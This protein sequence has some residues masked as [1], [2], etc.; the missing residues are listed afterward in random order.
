MIPCQLGC[1][2][3]AVIHTWQLLGDAVEMLY[4]VAVRPGLTV[5]VCEKGYWLG[6]KIP[7]AADFQVSGSMSLGR[8]YLDDM[9]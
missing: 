9:T 8:L 5:L 4:V 3:P 1:F 2:L 6:L 7:L